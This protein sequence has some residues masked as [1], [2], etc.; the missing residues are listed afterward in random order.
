M[1]KALLFS[2]A[3]TVLAMQKTS[4]QYT[5]LNTDPMDASM[6]GAADIKTVSYKMDLA[7]DSLWLKVETH[8][9]FTNTADFGIMFGIDTNQNPMDGTTWMG[10]NTSMKYDQAL[11]V[12]Q[13]SMMP[14]Y[15]GFIGQ[16]GSPTSMPVFVT[17][18]DNY[19]FIFRVKLSQIDPNHKF[20]MIVGGGY[21]DIFNT[22]NV[23]DDAPNSG[24]L[25]VQLN[26]T[27][28]SAITGSGSLRV[29]PNPARDNFTI[30]LPDNTEGAILLFDLTGRQVAYQ[31]ISG[32]DNEVAVG[33][34]RAGVY[35]YQV[36][37]V[38]GDAVYR[39]LITVNP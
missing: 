37:N 27:G 38:S 11:F 6:S 17:R 24:A 1:K 14:G 26:T 31:A 19:T 23:Y 30:T 25:T 8:N 22:G 10:M 2:L 29:Y 36:V 21:F 16:P 12:I 13:N 4:A 20:N 32:T 18:P 5:L 7:H 34:L 35:V 15:M 9:S 33:S 39:G 28:I 3:L